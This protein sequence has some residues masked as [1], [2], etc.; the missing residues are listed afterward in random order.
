MDEPKKS[1]ST[2]GFSLHSAATLAMLL[3]LS[4]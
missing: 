3:E 4:S 2:Q 1:V